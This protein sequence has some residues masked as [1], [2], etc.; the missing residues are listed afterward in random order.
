VLLL[1]IAA[2][3]CRHRRVLPRLIRAAAPPRT[4]S[5]A[6]PD[7]T[8]STPASAPGSPPATSSPPQQHQPH[9]QTARSQRRSAVDAPAWVPGQTQRRKRHTPFLSRFSSQPTSGVAVAPLCSRPTRAPA[10]SRVDAYKKLVLR[11]INAG[12]ACL[13]ADTAE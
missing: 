3:S 5:H 10:G 12:G 13:A 2:R 11:K 7:A 1:M 6:E 9:P 8:H 4:A